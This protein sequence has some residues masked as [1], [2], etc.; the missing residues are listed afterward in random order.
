MMLMMM[1]MMMMI[2]MMTMKMMMMMIRGLS[3]NRSFRL[4]N[5][6][7]EKD[8]HLQVDFHTNQTQRRQVIQ[9]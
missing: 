2:M 6:A 5:H 3:S 9:I 7:Y 1:M 8:F 4:R